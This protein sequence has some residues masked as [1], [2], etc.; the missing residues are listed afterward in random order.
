MTADPRAGELADRLDRLRDRLADEGPVPSG[1]SAELRAA[2]DPWPVADAPA[3]GPWVEAARRLL[4]MEET[5]ECLAIEGGAAADG[6]PAYF[7]GALGRLAEALRSGDGAPAAAWIVGESADGWG[8]YLRLLDPTIGSAT[9]P[10]ADP[11]DEPEAEPGPGQDEPAFD[12]AALLRTIGGAVPAILPTPPPPAPPPAPATATADRDGPDLV[13]EA[14]ALELD[15]ELRAI[16]AAD[17]ADLFGRLQEQVLGLGDAEEGPRL[18]E[19]GRCYHT[20]K[21]AAG[22]VGLVRLADAIHELEDRLERAGGRASADLIGRLERSLAQVEGVL[23][24][25]GGGEAPDR[26]SD[27]GPSESPDGLVRIPADRFEDL[28]DLCSDLLGR[29]RAWADRAERTK[30]LADAA[31]TCSHRLRASVD[32]LGEAVHRS[33]RRSADGR[34]RRGDDL[35]GLVRRMTEQ[36]EDLAAL[37]AT[38]REVSIA[39]SEEAESCS[40]LALRL[41]ET[42]QSVR[43]VPVRGL[44]QRLV[45]VAREAARVEGRTIEVELIGEETGADRV[46][47]D[48]AYEPLLHVV[49]NAVGHGIEPPEVRARAGKPAVGR[50]ALEARREGHAL[51]IA[52]SDDG[53]GLDLDAIA[54]RGRRQGLIGPDERP[55]VERLRALIFQP[56]FSTRNQAN[57][58]A[59]R[60][61]GMD[62]V[63]REVEQLRGRVELDSEAGRGTRLSMVLPARLSLEHVM[64]VRVGGRAFAVPIAAIDSVHR[65]AGD[66]SA[67]DDRGRPVATIGDRRVPLADLGAI[68]GIPGPAE[69][70]CPILLMTA[71]DGEPLALRVDRID[72]ALELVIRPLG[73]LLTGHPA[74]SGVGLTTGGEIVPAIDLAGLL[75]LASVARPGPDRTVAGARP[76][77]LVVDDSLSV[78]RIALR[79]LRALGLEVDEAADGEQALGEL[80]RRTYRLILTDLEM[81]RMEGFALLAE[82]G[83]TGAL[84]K[85]PVV[86]T[87][88]RSDP[89]TR[90]RVL[91]LGARAFVAKPVDADELAAVVG[92]LLGRDAQDA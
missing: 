31:R 36:A 54:A 57:A 64:V 77:A 12:L 43:V 5:W 20:L 3:D 76:R 55:S 37:A 78:R 89:E 44:F 48:R 79:N 56:G 18:G 75:R 16:F 24:V 69:L 67:V 92:G 74:I 38:A 90:R 9:E 1:W 83:R 47:L 15:P 29:R 14:R 91:G 26:P 52:V 39:E 59:G 45:R 50:I 8:E 88:T 68:L 19:I 51:A 71:A 4:L 11:W 33:A 63:A 58:I 28:T 66:G 84:E 40:R 17:L 86:V 82:L 23:G 49:R 61:V 25:V 85:T 53:R 60:G 80:R 35:A 30:Q 41:W 22:S 65:H 10:D 21:G 70:P 32:R 62:V 73:P 13:A 34:D 7:D 6:L 87:S 42:L 2:L 27:A 81:P 72:G 46:L